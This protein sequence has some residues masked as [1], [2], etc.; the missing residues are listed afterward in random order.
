MEVCEPSYGALSDE[1]SSD[2]SYDP[3]YHVY[4]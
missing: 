3:I 2:L 4:Q 1:E